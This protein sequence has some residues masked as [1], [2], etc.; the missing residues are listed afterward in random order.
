MQSY[1]SKSLYF[2]CVSVGAAWYKALGK[3][4]LRWI[5]WSTLKERKMQSLE[6]LL[7]L[8]PVSL[9]TEKGRLRWLR[10]MEYK[11]DAELLI[12]SGVVQRKQTELER[13]DGAS[14][15]DYSRAS[16]MI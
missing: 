16:K 14:K 6:I 13:W 9:V 5:C 8:E 15:V 1:N 2:S 10:H 12:E 4:E 7:G 11:D 3:S